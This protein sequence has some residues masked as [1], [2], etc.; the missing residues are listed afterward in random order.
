M[1]LL[2]Y[3]AHLKIS[4]EYIMESEETQAENICI[5]FEQVAEANILSGDIYN[6]EKYIENALYYAEKYNLEYRKAK[7]LYLRAKIYI[8]KEEIF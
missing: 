8:D 6:A 3:L 1:D 4:V 2:E 7:N 5:Y